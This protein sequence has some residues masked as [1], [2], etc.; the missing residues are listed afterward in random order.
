MN[1]QAISM[2]FYN[3]DCGHPY[4][5][6]IINGEGV[7]LSVTDKTVF[8]YALSRTVTVKYDGGVD[9][10]TLAYNAIIGET[11]IDTNSTTGSS[12]DVSL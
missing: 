7:D 11:T 2:R 4:S 10:V 3:A 1:T 12:I 9:G 6:Y 5:P 8:N